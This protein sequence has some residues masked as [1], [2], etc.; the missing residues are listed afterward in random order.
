MGGARIGLTVITTV[1]SILLARKLTAEEFG[2][3]DM[4]V[5]AIMM[6]S[7]FSGL[8]LSFA[9]IQSQVARR[10]LAFHAFIITS[11]TGGVLALVIG[12]LAE[13]IASLFG[14]AAAAP[15]FRWLAP[16][17]LF[18]G[19]GLIPDALMQKDMLFG[20]VSAVAILTEIAYVVVA[21]TLAYSGYGVWS[22]VWALFVRSALAVTTNWVLSPGWDWIRP[23]PWDWNLVRSLLRFG[24]TAAGGGLIT[25]AYSMTD[26]FAVSRWLGAAALGVYQR[27]VNLTS[28][29][30][31]GMNNA[32]SAVLLPSYVQL[33]NDPPRLSQAYLKSL[34][35]L[36]IVLVPVGCG[37]MVLARDLV[38]TLLEARWLPMVLPFQI[39]SMVS[40]VKP[41][42][43]TTSVL[44]TAVG[45]PGVNFKAGA[46][47]LAVMIPM[48]VVLLPF[49]VGGVACAVLVSQIA[50]F[51]Y[52]L[53]Q[54]HK[55]LPGTPIGM[56]RALRP[57]LFAGGVMVAAVSVAIPLVHGWTGQDAGIVNLVALIA[58]GV[59]SYTGALY[60][61]QPSLPGELF[62][63]ILKRK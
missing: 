58:I 43:A 47:V 40:T 14:N 32:V 24:L 39:F 1:S 3:V 51:V 7:L 34:R 48:I 23:V 15:V 49:G 36:G 37:L 45:R 21:V 22:L 16:M 25:F 46:I 4:A 31:D 55:V 20:R 29:S 52:N 27:S 17:V 2:F 56:F 12:L 50:G 5:L 28:R 61:V 13:P 19:L 33:Q 9:V 30:I 53:I 38:V 8:G 18:G 54:V 6:T 62:E 11:T 35:L 44:F 60:A 42:S 63:L 10:P 26:G 57:S 41:L 59:I